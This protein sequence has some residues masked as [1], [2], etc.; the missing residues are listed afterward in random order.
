MDEKVWLL[1]FT[2]LY[3]TILLNK[4]AKIKILYLLDPLSTLTKKSLWPIPINSDA[5]SALFY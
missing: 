2:V 3:A 4:I 5:L 1:I